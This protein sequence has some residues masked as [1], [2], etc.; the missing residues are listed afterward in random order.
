MLIING[1]FNNFV[2]KMLSGGIYNLM[3]TLEFHNA[4]VVTNNGNLTLTGA[5]GQILDSSTGN[6]G[7]VALSL[8]NTKGILSL[9]TGAALTTTTKVNNKGKLTV[10][11]GSSLKAGSSYKQSAGTTVDGTLTAPAGLTLKGGSVAG[12]GTISAAVT[13]SGGQVTVGDS[14]TKSGILTVTSY[15]QN[16]TTANLNVAIGGNTVGTQY[17]QPAVANGMA[18]DGVLNIKLINSFIPTIGSTSILKGTAVTGTFSTVNGTTIN[19][20]EHFK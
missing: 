18:L 3:G 8:N 12:M 10:G 7:L 13:A 11:T 14:T 2:K 9:Q 15:T 4:S 19:S 16:T 5:G 20:N 1:T 17:S 6:N